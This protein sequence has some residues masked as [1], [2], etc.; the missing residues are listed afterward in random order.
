MAQLV[1]GI[2]EEDGELLRS[3]ARW[4]ARFYPQVDVVI[5][6]NL[7]SLRGDGQGELDSIWAA[8]LFNERSIARSRDQRRRLIERLTS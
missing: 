8:A 7:I 5:D 1:I 3:A 6:G 2:S 4:L